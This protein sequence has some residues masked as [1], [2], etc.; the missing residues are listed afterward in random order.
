MNKTLFI[1]AYNRDNILLKVIKKAKSCK[2]YNEYNKILVLQKRNNLLDKKIV[3]RVLK[4]DNSIKII[5]TFFSN[6]HT[7]FSKYN[8]NIYLGFRLGFEYFKSDFVIHLE[9]DILPAYDCFNFLEHTTLTYKDDNKYF[10]TAA[11]SKEFNFFSN[12]L[13]FTYSKFIYGIG[14]KGWSLHKNNW[15]MFKNLVRPILI[16]TASTFIDCYIEQT[17]KKSFFVVM[18]YRSRSFE[19]PSNGMNT[20]KKALSAS[21]RMHRNKWYKS[22]LKKNFYKIQNYTYKSNIPFTWRDDCIKYNL[23]NRFLYLHLF[24]WLKK[25]YYF[26]IIKL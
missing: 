23:I 20:K 14:T 17:I 4:I 10:A 7:I 12:S 18:P 8:N 11:F 22:F 24:K 21:E 15:K 3:K 6:K 19:I 9:D 25:F 2:G 13:N 16:P 1:S 5:K 26:I